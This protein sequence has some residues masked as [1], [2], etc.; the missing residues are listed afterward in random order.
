[1]ICFVFLY[2]SIFFVLYMVITGIYM[3]DDTDDSLMGE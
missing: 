2:F 3:I 1:M